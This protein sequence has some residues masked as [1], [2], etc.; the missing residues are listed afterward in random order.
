[1]D[2][3]ERGARAELRVPHR[4][5]EQHGLIRVVGARYGDHSQCAL[6]QL[7]FVIM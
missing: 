3:G 5:Q 4:I 2:G 1:M 6:F 7:L